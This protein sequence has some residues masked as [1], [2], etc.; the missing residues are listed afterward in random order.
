MIKRLQCAELRRMAETQRAE[1]LKCSH[2]QTVR[3][4]VQVVQRI[5][6]QTV[7]IDIVWTWIW[8]LRTALI[9]RVARVAGHVVQ[10]VHQ[11]MI[12]LHVNSRSLLADRCH[13]I[14]FAEYGVKSC[15]VRYVCQF[16]C[17]V[18]AWLQRKEDGPLIGRR[19]R[20]V[21]ARAGKWVR[22]ESVH[23]AACRLWL[24]SFGSVV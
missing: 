17:P 24:T 13:T 6:G 3:A 5:A 2:L 4:L 10:A 14:Q 9:G 18:I 8:G 19:R 20:Y 16:D 1:R 12:T 7:Q 22:F 23:T 21:Q 15:A 11:R